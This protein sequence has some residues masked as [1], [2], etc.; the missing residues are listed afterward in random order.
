MKAWI[1]FTKVVWTTA[2]RSYDYDT[3]VVGYD[4]TSMRCTAGINAGSEVRK[5]YL[6]TSQA[7]NQIARYESGLYLVMDENQLALMIEA[8]YISDESSESKA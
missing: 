7:D 5:V 1:G 8:T 6:R 2:P 3:I 4:R